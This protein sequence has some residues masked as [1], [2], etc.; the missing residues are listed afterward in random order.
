MSLGNITVVPV[1][2]RSEL[3]RFAGFN[4]R[5]YRDNPYA[6]PEL[7][8]DTKNAFTPSGNAAFDFC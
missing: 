3:R 4:V 7:I 1:R 5:L 6:V 2:T 8:T